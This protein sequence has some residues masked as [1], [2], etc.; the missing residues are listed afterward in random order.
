M[1]VQQNPLYIITTTLA[2]SRRCSL[3]WPLRD[4]ML[5]LSGDVQLQCGSIL[6]SQIQLPINSPY[7]TLQ[8]SFME[9]DRSVTLRWPLLFG[10]R[11]IQT[12][13]RRQF[14]TYPMQD[15]RM[16]KDFLG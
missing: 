16:G 13:F 12:D 7:E 15:Y 14:A 2:P 1:A 9:M 8:I 6:P 11:E 4:V 3:G 10:V 5:M